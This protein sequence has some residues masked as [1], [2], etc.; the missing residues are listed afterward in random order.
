MK[1]QATFHRL[2]HYSKPRKTWDCQPYGWLFLSKT[3]SRSL[4]QC[5]SSSRTV[6]RDL[7]RQFC[8]SW[9]SI[10]HQITL[11]LY[12]V[13]TVQIVIYG[14][15]TWRVRKDSWNKDT[16][17]D[18]TPSWSSPTCMYP[19]RIAQMRKVLCFQRLYGTNRI[20][21]ITACSICKRWKVTQYLT[22]LA[23]H[24]P[25]QMS[26]TTSARVIWPDLR[27]GTAYH[28]PKQMSRTTSARVIGPDL[29]SR[30]E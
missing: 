1:I 20:T 23:Y 13:M 30:T 26:R 11:K 22:D 24:T 29:R 21:G 4:F 10:T 6:H 15:E 12:E 3:S 19:E 27:A 16:E 18:E 7:V 5:L 2:E 28:T 8:S 14:S 9:T 25:K 17:M